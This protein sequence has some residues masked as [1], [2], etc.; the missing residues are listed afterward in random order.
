MNRIAARLLPCCAALA[1]ALQGCGPAPVPVERNAQASSANALPAGHPPLD[2]GSMGG[3]AGGQTGGMPA[4]HPPLGGANMPAGHPTMP[5]ATDE[6]VR[7]AGVVRLTGPF[8]EMQEGYLFVSVLPEGVRMPCFSRKYELSDAVA[9]PDGDRLLSFVLDRNNTMAGLV[10]GVDKLVL[11][12]WFDPD[13][14]VDTKDGAVRVT[15]P[16]EP[17]DTDA[18]VVLGAG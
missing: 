4:G 3:Q 9:G 13:G 1:L 14:S 7:F 8:A 18:E 10:P 12:A 2:G 5:G 6:D 11:E 17:G 16:I 15:V